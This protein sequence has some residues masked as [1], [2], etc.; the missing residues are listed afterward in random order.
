MG[1]QTHGGRDGAKFSARVPS[2]VVDLGLLDQD[3]GRDQPPFD[4]T[5][6]LSLG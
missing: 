5:W 4:W 3:A 6:K 1:D 2:A